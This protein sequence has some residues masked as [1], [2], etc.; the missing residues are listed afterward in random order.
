MPL[1]LLELLL[2]ELLPH[3]DE[4]PEDELLVELD[5]CE[6]ISFVFSSCWQKWHFSTC[7]PQPAALVV[8]ACST[9]SCLGASVR[10]WQAGHTRLLVSELR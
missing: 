4:L 3:D 1:L 2:L 8:A 10:W 6:I 9:R 7:Q 5:N